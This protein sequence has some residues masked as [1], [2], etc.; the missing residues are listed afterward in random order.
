[1]YRICTGYI[2]LRVP[3][4]GPLPCY[5]LAVL[6]LLTA[7]CDGVDTWTL[8]AKPLP[9]DNVLL[10]WWTHYNSILRR[11]KSYTLKP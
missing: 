11:L 6:V 5:S 3:T 8:H 10:C 4:K 1:M 7:P 9:P 2:T